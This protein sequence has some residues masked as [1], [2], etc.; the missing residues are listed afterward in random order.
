[1]TY[2]PNVRTAPVPAPTHAPAQSAPPP[3]PPPARQ[4][5]WAEI[6]ERLRAAATTEPGRLQIIGAVLAL[7]VVVFGAVT[8]FQVAD[9]ASAAQDVVGRS[10]PLSADAANIYRSL[11]DADTAA[12]SGFLAGAQEPETVQKRY[13]DDIDTASRLLIKAATNTDSDSDSGRQIATL[14]EQLPRYTGLIE[15]ARANNRQ[16]LPLGGAYLRYAN[17]QMT[18]EILPAAEKLYASETA[19]LDQDTDSARVWPFLALGAGVAA[20]GLLAW[21]QR[22]NY[23]RT[24]R[25]FNHGLLAATAAS[26]VVVLWLAVGHTVARADLDNATAH[27]QASLKVLNDARISSLKARANENLTLVARGAVL[28]KDG[29]SDQYETDYLSNM[30]ALGTTLEDARKLADDEEGSQP[31]GQ[32]RTAATEWQKRH[33]SANDTDKAGDYVGAL[34]KV[35]GD[36]DST[37]ESFDQV[38]KALA[39]AIDHEQKEFTDSAEGGRDALTGLAIGAVVLALLGAVG[40]ILGINRRLSEYR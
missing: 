11:A 35:V 8:A 29:K 2:P 1:M 28:T 6:R 3:A 16:G 4:G 21:A 10:Q 18:K 14:N 25:V 38:D 22:R 30:K 5:A 34:E 13:R 27:G 23:E 19:R 20:L 26:T 15:R 33:K 12:A 9:R 40:A 7:L 24:N 36:K 32:A 37:G 39:K 17:Q 31:V